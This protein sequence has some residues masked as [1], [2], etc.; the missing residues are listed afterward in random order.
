MIAFAASTASVRPL[1]EEEEEFVAKESKK[2]RK[3]REQAKKRAAAE[4]LHQHERVSKQLRSS[5]LALLDNAAYAAVFGPDARGTAVLKPDYT[6]AANRFHLN[7]NHVQLLV[8]VA[9]GEAANHST[10]PFVF[11]HQALIKR[12]VVI[13]LGGV[14]LDMID[15]NIS[16]EMQNMF[17]F[18]HSIL[19][20]PGSST[21]AYHLPPMVLRTP[22]ARPASAK[23]TK[24]TP[25]TLEELVATLDQLKENDF[26]V[27]NGP[28]GLVGLPE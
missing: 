26:P 21:K 2:Q 14:T 10:S 17:V 15:Q 23:K 22:V 19:V 16:T 24:E 28:D 18:G 8:S 6:L 5:P 3:K 27:E 20:G 9:A 4:S 25:A 1:M 11:G 12:V 13:S 7:P